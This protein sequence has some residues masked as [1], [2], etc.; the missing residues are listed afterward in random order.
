[1]MGVAISS[2]SH[3]TDDVFSIAAAIA[4]S[5]AMITTFS[6]YTD[7]ADTNNSQKNDTTSKPYHSKE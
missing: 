3:W 4:T 1:M 5:I 7:G 2:N 6:V